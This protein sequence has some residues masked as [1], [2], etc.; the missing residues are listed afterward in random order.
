MPTPLV[1]APSNPRTA[2]LSAHARGPD[3]LLGLGLVI[4]TLLLVVGWTAPMMTVERLFLFESD[5]SLVGALLALWRDSEYL[6][7]AIIALFSVLF[8]LAK[9]GMSLHLW[10][11]A[12]ADDPLLPQRLHRLEA[13]GKWS[14]LDV[15]LVAITIATVKISLISD[16]HMH[17]GLYAFAGGVVVSMAVFAR[18]T[19][20]AGRLSHP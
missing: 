12:Q 20:L 16:V 4:A 14:M 7:C 2:R 10:L 19:T 15:F 13:L 6:L 18:M 5:V 1:P 3:R 17:W 11:F 8:P 9:L